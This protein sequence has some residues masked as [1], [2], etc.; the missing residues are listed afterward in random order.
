MPSPATPLPAE[1]AAGEAELVHAFHDQMPTGVTVADDGR[2]FVCNPPLGRR[3][4]VHLA[5]LRDGRELPFPDLDVN[6]YSEATA[7]ERLVSVQSVVMDPA[8][9]LWLLDTGSVESGRRPAHPDRL[10]SG[11]ACAAERAEGAPP[12]GRRALL[13]A[14]YGRRME[15]TVNGSSGSASALRRSNCELTTR[16]RPR[17][18][19]AVVGYMNVRSVVWA[20]TRPERRL[21]DSRT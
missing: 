20:T 10:R 4:R 17:A 19:A 5:E 7:A 14:S 2:I 16:S 21:R 13:S 18:E 6:Q 15:L 9:R 1:R 12:T 11:A 8:G 3:R